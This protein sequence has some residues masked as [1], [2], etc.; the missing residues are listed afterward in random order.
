MS[1]W[2]LEMSSSPAVEE[3]EVHPSPFVSISASVWDH[4]YLPTRFGALLDD[5][6]VH[7]SGFVVGHILKKLSCDVCRGSLV[8]D[9]TPASCDQSCHLLT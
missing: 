4:T 9:A 8:P 3:A 1:L 2:A 5:A 6:L 7:I